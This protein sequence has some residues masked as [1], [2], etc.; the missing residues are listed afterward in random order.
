MTETSRTSVGTGVAA[1]AVTVTLPG[2]DDRN[3][4]AR[5][6]KNQNHRQVTFPVT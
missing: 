4:P 5:V 2:Y 1:L 3:F 6:Q